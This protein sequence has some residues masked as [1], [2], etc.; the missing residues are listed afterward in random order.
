[1]AARPDRVTAGL[2]V[3]HLYRR[4]PP[5]EFFAAHEVSLYPGEEDVVPFPRS[6]QSRR[7]DFLALRLWG[8][9]VGHLLGFEVK[10]SRSDFLQELR[11]PEKRVPLEALCS[12]CY[13][14]APRGVFDVGELPEGWGW[15]EVRSSGLV[16]RREAK[17]R[18]CATPVAVYHTLMKR[19]HDIRWYDRARRPALLDWPKEVFEYAGLPVT[20]GKLEAL[21][22]EVFHS[23]LRDREHAAR[24][25]AEEE[26]KGR[27]REAEDA[28]D[29][30]RRAVGS[31]LGLSTWDVAALTPEK[32]RGLLSVALTT[33]AKPGSLVRD[34]ENALGLLERS[35]KFIRGAVTQLSPPPAEPGS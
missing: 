3:T 24:R 26:M 20:P 25:A 12:A 34:L 22:A 4:F 16:M 15:L 27:V 11:D 5:P 19:L 23:T 17:H 30:F 2:A 10:V 14:V 13:F 35:S 1:M 8:A 7:A 18:A 28:L 31:V 9:R 21:A 29:G 32:V 6:G 33:G